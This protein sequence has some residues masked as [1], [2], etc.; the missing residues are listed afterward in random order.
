M[1]KKVL[2]YILN[3][4]KKIIKHHKKLSDI[5]I[6]SKQGQGVLT[7]AD[8][9]SEKI[10][11]S[12]LKKEFPTHEIMS[13]EQFYFNKESIDEVSTNHLWLV[14][15]IDGTNNFLSGFDH[16]AISIGYVKNGNLEFGV[17]YQPLRSRLYWAQAD[18][19]AFFQDLSNSKRKR[20]LR[21]AHVQKRRKDLSLITSMC[22]LISNKN[23]L[24]Q[25]YLFNEQVRSVRR[26][27]SA[28]LDL[29]FVADGVFDGFYDSGLMPW[30][31]AAGA[32]IAKEAGLSVKNYDQSAFDL[33]GHGIIAARKK[34]IVLFKSILGNL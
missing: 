4:S 25:F 19:G 28:A 27:G 24:E 9:E 31:I 33:F 30:D 16:F 17:V 2:P 3:A 6:T 23:K 12:G 10:L 22:K 32:L 13:E 21:G 11:L 18:K 1:I 15:P 20:S 5:E 7:E 14:D 29:C 8:L 34:D 26:L